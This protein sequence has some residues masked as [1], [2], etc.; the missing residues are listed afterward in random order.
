MSQC[1]WVCPVFLF[2]SAWHIPGYFLSGL[3]T[4]K[5]RLR[6]L[7]YTPALNQCWLHWYFNFFF[8]GPL[9]TCWLALQL[10]SRN[11]HVVLG[12]RVSPPQ[13]LPQPRTA[14]CRNSLAALG[15]RSVWN[16]IVSLRSGK[17]MPFLYSHAYTLKKNSTKLGLFPPLTLSS[18]FTFF[19]KHWR[20]Q[21]WSLTALSI[22]H[23]LCLLKCWLHIKA[24]LNTGLCCF[25][26]LCA[27]YVGGGVPH[28][29]GKEGGWD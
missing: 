21:S 29:V 11:F 16:N 13:W 27:Q 4:G 14:S 9:H 23:V 1:S 2:F 25:M 18:C 17:K 8:I 10:R 22:Q 19:L 12:E 20:I 15:N 24:L 28:W 7:P 26:M 6:L 5:S 3:L